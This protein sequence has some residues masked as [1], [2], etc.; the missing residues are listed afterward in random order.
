MEFCNG[1]TLWQAKN[2]K[3]PIALHPSKD[4]LL[5]LLISAKLVGVT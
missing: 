2:K 4:L 1:C 3:V 5:D